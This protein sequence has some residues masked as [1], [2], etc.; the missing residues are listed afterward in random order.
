MLAGF[1]VMF[2]LQPQVV[3]SLRYAIFDAYQRLFPFEPVNEP[4][5]IVAIDEKS[6][7]AIGQWPWPRARVAKLVDQIATAR[8]A[9]I[10]FDV[11][12]AEQDRYNVGAFAS[13]I[14]GLSPEFVEKLRAQPSDDQLFARAL[15]EGNT[16]LAMAALPDP[17]PEAGLMP[18]VAPVRVKATA[19][20][21]FKRINNLLL[22]LPELDQAAAGRGFISEDAEDGIVRRASL[23]ARIGKAGGIDDAIALSLSM[24]MLRV[25][26]GGGVSIT[27][28]DGGVLEVKLAELAFPAQDNGSIWLRHSRHND[29]RFISAIDVMKG[30]IPREK[31]E[32]KMVLVGLTGLGL[33]D[34]KTT[35]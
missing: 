34:F 27:D 1:V 17:K 24:E 13:M 35:V 23:F 22:S 29:N 33:F 20:L 25:A 4:V 28:L 15:R 7:K 18:R 6:L 11:L 3:L 26:S 12:F 21:P 30:D 10:G 9:V 14:P 2:T 31:I 16:V 8:P 5:V 19:A 32:G